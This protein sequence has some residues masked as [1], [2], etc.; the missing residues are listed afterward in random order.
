MDSFKK[1]AGVKT[2]LID[3]NKIVRDTLALAFAYKKCFIEAVA[4]AEAG[5][6]A[7]ER[8]HFDVIIC[9]FSLPGINGVEFFQQAVRSHPNAIRI[10][11]SG[12]GH[13]ETIAEAFEAGVHE[14]M[15]KPFSLTALADQLAPHVDR[16]LAAKR[17]RPEFDEKKNELK[18]NRTIP[19][20]VREELSLYRLNPV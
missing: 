14:F 6:R 13:D 1:L 11:I 7:I 3:D 12:Y 16:Y 2:L 8:E 18:G 17:D 4:S 9:D 15:K 5:L 10:L 19:P 20:G